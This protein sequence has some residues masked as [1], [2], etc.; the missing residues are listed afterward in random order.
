[1]ACKTK[2]YEVRDRGLCP[3]LSF[4]FASLHS[5]PLLILQEIARAAS[6]HEST[7]RH[8]YNLMVPSED[9]LLPEAEMKV[10]LTAPVKV[11]EAK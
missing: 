6:I 11:E 3:L 8:I 5:P 2:G 7:V 1:M 10:E 4:F 9:E